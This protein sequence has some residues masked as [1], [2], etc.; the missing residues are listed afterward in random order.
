MTESEL[1]ISDEQL[2]QLVDALLRSADK[3]EDGVITFD[4][5]A[6]ELQKYPNLIENLTIRY[7]CSFFMK[8]MRL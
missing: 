2:N 3:D 8:K 7:L 6:Q 5:L 4:E 1:T